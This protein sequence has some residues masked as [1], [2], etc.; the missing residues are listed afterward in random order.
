MTKLINLYNFFYRSDYRINN[1]ENTL[2]ARAIY[3]SNFLPLQRYDALDL[4]C[5]NNSTLRIL[6]KL[7]FKNIIGVDQL[8]IMDQN[9]SDKK[10]KY[11][12]S[13]LIEYLK[14]CKDS[15]FDLITIFDVIEHIPL[16]SINLLFENVYRVLR[17]NGSFVIQSPNGSS[18]F[19]G[20][21]FYGDPT[22]V[23]CFNEF[24]LRNLLHS[25]GFK[26][27]KIKLL[28]CLPLLLTFK[29]FFRRL[30]WLLIRNIYRVFFII[31]TGSSPNALT[32]VFLI[33]ATK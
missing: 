23:F 11:V 5:G 19:F 3:L 26:N 32:R 31:E 10:I 8:E 24:S 20:S 16:D 25:S 2:K 4:G 30:L 18:P 21:I 9:Y 12:K 15:S 17:S 14:G 33:G 13:D 1:Y 22:H 6:L 29:S 7:G 27:E 28:E